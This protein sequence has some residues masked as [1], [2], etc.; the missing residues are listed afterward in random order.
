MIGHIWTTLIAVVAGFV[1]LWE[2]L[3]VPVS[4]G[5][6]S[7]SASGNFSIATSHRLLRQ[8]QD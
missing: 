8:C 3:F 5:W 4:S 2:L 7:W 1:L 6:M